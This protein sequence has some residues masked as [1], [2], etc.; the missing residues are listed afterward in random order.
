MDLAER[1]C[2]DVRYTGRFWY[3]T[4]WFHYQSFLGGWST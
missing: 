3:C 2:K 1:V 4:V